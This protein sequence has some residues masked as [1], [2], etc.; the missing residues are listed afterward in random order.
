MPRLQKN[1]SSC[2]WS[3]EM[4]G[5]RLL[6]LST[7]LNEDPWHRL[8]TQENFQKNKTQ[9]LIRGKILLAYN[10]I[11]MKLLKHLLKKHLKWH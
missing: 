1:G 7:Y 11:L 4:W 9:M 5:G 10:H 3:V 2:Y 6:F 8:G